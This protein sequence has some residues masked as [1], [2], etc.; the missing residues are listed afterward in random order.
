MH[1]SSGSGVLA[2]TPDTFYQVERYEQVIGDGARL[3]VYGT[4]RE[5]WVPRHLLA[6]PVRQGRIHPYPCDNNFERGHGRRGQ[7]RGWVFFDPRYF[8]YEDGQ[9]KHRFS[10]EENE[11]FMPGVPFEEFVEA[12]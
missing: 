8:V 9:W 12:R 2:G 5:G 4:C 6:R 1:T 7:A 10:E 11:L 3:E